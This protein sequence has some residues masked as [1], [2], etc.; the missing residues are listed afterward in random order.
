M[1]ANM[2][3]NQWPGSDSSPSERSGD[4]GWRPPALGIVLAGHLLV[5]I[6]ERF[7]VSLAVLAVVAWVVPFDAVR[8]GTLCLLALVVVVLADICE[9]LMERPFA[10]RQKLSGP[11]IPVPVTVLELA[12]FVLIAS[13][14]SWVV[15]RDARTT[16][17]Y[18]GCL[19]AVRVAAMLASDKPWQAGPSQQENDRIAEQLHQATLDTMR[20]IR[21]ERE[22]KLREWQ[23]RRR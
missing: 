23:R 13:V 10:Y 18:A 22:A 19:L 11:T 7:P 15:S 4:S 21:E 14:G 12:V 17:V 6:V 1:S 2:S 20:E 9:M 16:I 5:T 8:F 3:V